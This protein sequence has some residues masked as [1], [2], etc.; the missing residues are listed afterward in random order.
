MDEKDDAKWV[1]CQH[2]GA[3]GICSNTWNLNRWISCDACRDAAYDALCPVFPRK[4]FSSGK[5]VVK[6]SVCN[7]KGWIYLA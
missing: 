7:G 2:C 1:K 3:H 6:C 4:W 5:E